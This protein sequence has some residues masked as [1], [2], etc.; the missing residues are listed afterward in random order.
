[1]KVLRDLDINIDEDIFISGLKS[2]SGLIEKGQCFIALQ[3]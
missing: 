2:S 3:G 1:M